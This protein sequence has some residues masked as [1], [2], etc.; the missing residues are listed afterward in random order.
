MNTLLIKIGLYIAHLGGF[1]MPDVESVVIPIIRHE[2]NIKECTLIYNRAR[3][4]YLEYSCVTDTI[5]VIRKLDWK[6]KS[7]F[8]TTVINLDELYETLIKENKNYVW[9]S[10]RTI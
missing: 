7:E 9:A 10:S 5:N 8:D 3:R 2:K 4:L 1:I 6:L